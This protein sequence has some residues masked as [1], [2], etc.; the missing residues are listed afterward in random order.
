MQSAVAVRLRALGW[1]TYPVALV[2]LTVPLLDA[3]LPLW[4]LRL[5]NIA[6]RFA[7]VGSFSRELFTPLF[8]L[9]LALVVSVLLH[10]RWVSLAL[11]VLCGLAAL[12][13]VPVTALFMLD[14]LVMRTGVAPTTQL[15]L[16][17]SSVQAVGHLFLATAVAGVLSLVA[18]QAFRRSSDPRKGGRGAPIPLVVGRRSV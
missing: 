3:F 18:F 4:P 13:L 5:W 12:I 11:A 16:D 15:S 1:A 14:V 17:V 6:W 2:L 10:Q 7:A 8:G 9:L